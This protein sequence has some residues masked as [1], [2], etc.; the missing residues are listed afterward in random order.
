MSTVEVFFPL[1][2]ETII[3]M[4]IAEL[5]F[6]GYDQFWQDEDGLRAY[7]HASNLNK[8]LVEEISSK[9]H[10]N[11]HPIAYT[12]QQAI[13]NEWERV[14]EADG[15]CIVV[16]D[17]L[18]IVAQNAK[19]KI[20]VPYLIKMDAQMAFGNGKHPS[21]IGCLEQLLMLDFK[22]STVVDVGCGSGILAI[23]AEK[24]GA[25]RILAFDNNP[26]AVEVA[27]QAIMVNN[28]TGIVL[29]NIEIEEALEDEKFDFVLA[30]LNYAVFSTEFK[31]VMQLAKPTGKIVIGGFMN[32]DESNIIRMEQSNKFRIVSRLERESWVTHLLIKN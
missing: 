24:M 25:E 21:T 15:E 2:N 12:I 18:A 1:K 27:E 20:G 31:K 17:R 29:K 30:N 4:L 14:Q 26:W 10:D 19:S 7:I 9:Y 32:K 23:L 8:Q 28:C 22:K 13:P 3:E 6:Q 5:S 16:G 11:G